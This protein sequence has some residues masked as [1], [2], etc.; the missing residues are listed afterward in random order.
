LY[1]GMFFNSKEKFGFVVITNGCAP[2]YEDGFNGLIKN[3]INCL[4][5]SFIL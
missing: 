3:V 4:Y 2:K 1:S 5:E